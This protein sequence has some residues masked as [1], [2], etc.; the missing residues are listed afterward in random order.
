MMLR[1]SIGK[2]HP[3]RHDRRARGV[4]QIEASVKAL[5]KWLARHPA[6]LSHTSEEWPFPPL[7][8]NRR[9]LQGFAGTWE[10]SSQAQ[11]IGGSEN[12]RAR[13]REDLSHVA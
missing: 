8:T 11:A 2:L 1:G 12:R 7:K 9:V 5:E 3:R 4:H 13:S 6:V 10:D